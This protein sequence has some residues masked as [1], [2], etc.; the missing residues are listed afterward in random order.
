MGSNYKLKYNVDI[1]MCIDVT[2]S[3]DGILDIVK[4]NALNFYG[5]LVSAMNVK[6]KVINE[7]RIKIIAFRDYMADGKNAM[8]GT[9]F[10]TMPAAQ[11]EFQRMVNSLVAKGG[12]DDPEDGLE[13]LA[14]AIKSDWT[15]PT[16]DS[17]RRHVIVVW[18]D[19]STHPLGFGNK[20]EYY[21]PVMAKDFE[22]LTEWWDQMD[23]QSKRLL[24]YAPEAPYWTNISSTWDKT[25]H[26]PSEAGN[27]LEEF[28]YKEILAEIVNT[29]G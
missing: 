21:P 6:G 15:A 23:K 26:F 19:A 29:I 22:Q 1:V 9:E 3:M 4:Q 27:G 17:K 10:L 2:G 13:A 12:G 7:L 20:S 18:T 14:Y 16:A 5:D 28:E 11:G 24:L 8:M 25:M